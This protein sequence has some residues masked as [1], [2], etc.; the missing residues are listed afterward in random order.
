MEQRWVALVRD[1]EIFSK[2]KTPLIFEKISP[3]SNTQP[4]LVFK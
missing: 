2:R 4:T 3:H 1:R